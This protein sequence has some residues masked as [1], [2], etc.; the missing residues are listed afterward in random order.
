MYDV[1]IAGGRVIDGA[2][3]PWVRAD[4]GVRDGR[5]AAVGDLRGARAARTL[6]AA[7][8]FVTPGFIDAHTHS[9]LALLTDPAHASKLLQGVTTE[10]IGQDG[11]SYAPVPDAAVLDAVRRQIAGWNG[12]GESLDFAWRTV[13]DFLDR[14]DAGVAANAAFLLPHAT[15]RMAVLGNEDRQATPPELE[16]MRAMVV[17]GLD[18]GAFGLSAGLTYAP[19]MYGNDDELVALCEPM[20]GTG[21]YYCPHHRNYGAGAL[22][23]YADS[24]EIARRAGVP[25]QLTH[26]VLPF[27]VNRG[28]AAELLALVDAARADGVDVTLDTYPYLA[29]MTYLAAYLP[30]W[31][32][33]GG[34]EAALARIADPGLRE[35]LRVALEVDGSDGFHGVPMDW[36]ETAIAGVSLERNAGLVGLRLREA[37]QRAGK[38]PIDFFCDL[39]VEERLD[40]SG[41]GHVGF[42]ETVREI[43]RHP[44]HVGGSDGILQGQRPHPRGW[45]T[46]ARYLGH[47]VREAGVLSWEGAVRKLTSLPAQRLGLFDRGLVRPGM[48]A[49]LVCLDPETVIDRATYEQPRRAPDGIPHVLVNGAVAVLDGE[50]TDAL[51]GR[52]LRR[53]G[54]AAAM[55][56][57][58][59]SGA[60]A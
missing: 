42:E 37:A 2:G 11:L 48:A 55:R 40:V 33:E 28:R 1:L 53:Q 46:F 9:D 18:D 34:E 35:R 36:T 50:R 22:Q 7:G 30:S 59:L 43:M 56:S 47:Y 14:F 29:G 58:A 23:A 57:S 39:L 27:E 41:I 32:H 24:I 51:A 45:G 17:A 31:V 3:N 52:S 13:G 5:I 12:M 8:L 10:V 20:R 15:I 4:V 54:S 49:D 6:D 16:R 25:V 21:G 19:G 44:A 26:A 60:S 38:R